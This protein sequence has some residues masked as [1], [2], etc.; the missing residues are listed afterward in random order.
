MNPR[1]PLLALTA[2]LSAG[3]QALETLALEIVTPA[4][5]RYQA[6]QQLGDAFESFESGTIAGETPPQEYLA[7]RCNGPW[8]ALKYRLPLASGPGYLLIAQGDSLL[9]QIV[10]HSVISEDQ[11]IAAMS[12]H[13]IDTE[14]RQVI[15]ALFE[16]ELVRGSAAA[17][18]LQLANGYQLE[19]RYTP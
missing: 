19:Y 4:G 9:L 5:H 3:V 16:V 2:S 8:G 1:I 18:Q 15:K 6:Q 7:I 14:P 11:A 13:C 17:Q 10:E 12:V